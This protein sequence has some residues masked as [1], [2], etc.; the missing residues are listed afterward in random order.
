M[1]HRPTKLTLATS[2]ITAILVANMSGPQYV[3][4]SFGTSL[5]AKFNWTAL[6]NSLVSTASFIGV[7][8]SGPLCAWL[9][10]RFGIR[11]CVSILFIIYQFD[12]LI[13]DTIHV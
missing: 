2:F 12:I 11:G 7:S 3:Y 5:A 13:N 10:E 1:F 9:V 6:Q 4:P 8:F